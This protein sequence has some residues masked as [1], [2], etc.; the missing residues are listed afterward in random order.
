MV[1][2]KPQAHLQLELHSY[3]S[4][5]DVNRIKI[6][7][8]RLKSKI[9]N[10]EKEKEYEKQLVNKLKE[11]LERLQRERSFILSQH[12]DV[13]QE[14]KDRRKEFEQVT[15]LAMS[16]YNEAVALLKEK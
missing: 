4:S 3:S 5:T 9:D 12:A 14:L 15:K 7:N 10:L 8:Y 1:E 6:E 13:L 11:E 2:K 16:V